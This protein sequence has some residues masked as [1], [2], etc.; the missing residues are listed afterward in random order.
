MMVSG[1][2]GWDL[3]SGMD[4]QERRRF[5][6]EDSGALGVPDYKMDDSR[7]WLVVPREIEAALETYAGHREPERVV[8]HLLG[9]EALPSWRR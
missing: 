5:A 6:A 3:A 2:W 4:D 7:A 9:A 8:E 1:Q